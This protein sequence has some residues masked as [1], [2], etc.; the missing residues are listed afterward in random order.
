MTSFTIGPPA[1]IRV[2]PK[3]GNSSRHFDWSV[4][5]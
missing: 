4:T 1:A 2:V 5:F 3:Y